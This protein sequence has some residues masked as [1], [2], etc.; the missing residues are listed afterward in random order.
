MYQSDYDIQNNLHFKDYIEKNKLTIDM[1]DSFIF[2]QGENIGVDIGGFLK[3]LDYVSDDDYIIKI[4]TKSNDVWRRQMM[5]IFSEKGIFNAAM[6]GFFIM[7]I[8]SI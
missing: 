4:H 6:Y 2:I 5:N 8:Y 3:C 1:C 7:L